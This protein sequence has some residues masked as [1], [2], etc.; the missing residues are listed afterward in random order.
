MDWNAEKYTKDFSFVHQYGESVLELIE[1]EKGNSV[2]DLGCGN[3]AL[4]QS[5][6]ERGFLVTGID[7]SKELLEIARKNYPEINFIHADATHFSLEKQVDIIFSNAVFHWIEKDKQ[8]L[9]LSC[10]NEA[11]KEKGQFIFEFGGY[12]NNALIHAALEQAFN[13]YDYEYKM[14][15]Y[16]PSIGEYA[17]LVE[18]TDLRVKS[19]VLFDRL[20][21]LKG[22][23]GLLD[24]IIMFNKTPFL[25]IEDIALREKTLEKAVN[26]LTDVLYIEGKWYADYV[27]IKMKA[28]KEQ[29]TSCF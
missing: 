7:A 4:S 18:K 17:S 2:I 21:E 14:P 6:K 11:L 29:K 1:G 8:I 13:E 16:F 10:V 23:D 28:I 20:T 9:M 25:I 27:R 3:G 19:A 12:G 26:S 24:W 5:L 22:E 15:F